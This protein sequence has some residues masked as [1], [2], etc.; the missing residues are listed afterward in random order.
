M[1]INILHEERRFTPNEVGW[2]DP[3]PLP[4]PERE[5]ML[6]RTSCIL[7]RTGC[8]GQ[9]QQGD[10]VQIETPLGKQREVRMAGLVGDFTRRSAPFAFMSLG[11]VTFDTMEWL[12]LPRGYNE[13]VIRV[14]GDSSNKAH[15]Q[16]VADRVADRIER[17]GVTVSHTVVPEPGEL[18]QDL[19]IRGLLYVLGAMGALALGS[20][21]FLLV[22]IMQ[23][24][25]TQQVRQIGVMK[26]FGAR[27]R[28]IAGMYLAIILVYGL[29]ALLIAA[30]AGTWIARSVV[31]FMEYL[32][33][34]QLSAFAIPPRVLG[35][36]AALA[37]FVPLL[38][39]LWP[40]LS[41]V[42]ITV[43]EALA[44][45][46][47]VEVDDG[48]IDRLLERV[49]GL[50]RPLLLSLRNTFRRK[51]RLVLTLVTL[52]LAGTIF[53]AVVS[54]RA[55]M[56][57]TLD[58]ALG[59]YQWDIG[60]TLN[61]PYR[62]DLIENVA[63][64]VP[65]VSAVESTGWANAY[66]LRPDGSEGKVFPV[67][68][69]LPG[70]QMIQPEIVQGRWLLPG[71]RD[72]LV[73]STHLAQK[74]PDVT[75]GGDIVLEIQ[76]RET[77]WRIV[78]IIRPPQ[79]DSEAYAANDYLLR[80]TRNVGRGSS[81]RVI[82]EQ[83]DR[84]YQA[85]LAEALEARFDLKGIS[86][87]NAFTVSEYREAGSQL[88]NIVITFLMSMAILMATVGG[89]GLMGT[90]LLNVLE[91]I[92]EVGVMRAIGA[93]TDAV[94]Q[95]FTVEGAIIGL[96]SWLIALFFAWPLGKVI[97]ST[98]GGQLMG[99]AR[100][101]YVFSLPGVGIWL[102]AAVLLSVVASYFPAQNAARLT[103]REVLSYQ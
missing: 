57:N 24:L 101:S 7:P 12:G 14:A 28:Q 1:D 85:Q 81:L 44:D 54:V 62:V 30:P 102:A 21:V 69:A 61:R 10:I 29:L 8:E 40:I 90:M 56:T 53:M 32:I 48:L 11:Y 47:M 86:V 66:R 38:A 87:R 6:E 17:T 72:A 79:P 75:V 82:S 77:T 63:L 59:F 3:V 89:I 95:I 92:R 36:E 84:A 60:I 4:P 35:L 98:V 27:G 49:R 25:L 99:G 103:V 5:V 31:G 94:V 100:V 22:N 67:Y 19:I 55:S 2:P 71:D 78:G 97:S 73:V 37:L 9:F 18:P 15:S 34:F 93:P 91:R 96:L 80:V 51:G 68:G 46:G 58:E 20:S 39:G 23:A 64:S 76:G 42:R 43:R 16:D 41:G 74:E 70:S 13:L 26:S 45:Y 65:G 83:H 33:N 52:V 88:Y 50:P